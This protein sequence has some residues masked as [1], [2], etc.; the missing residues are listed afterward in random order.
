MDDDAAPTH[1]TVIGGAYFPSLG[2][3]KMK[4]FA[5]DC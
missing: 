5:D 4:Q 3:F 1:H 2:V